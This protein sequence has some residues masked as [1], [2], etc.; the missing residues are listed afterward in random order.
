MRNLSEMFE[1]LSNCD[2]ETLM[3]ELNDHCDRLVQKNGTKSERFYKVD[4]ENLS[5][6]FRLTEWY[7]ESELPKMIEE[8]NPKSSADEIMTVEG[9]AVYMKVPPATVYNLINKGKLKKI[10]IS[11]VD[12]PGVRPAIRIRKSEIEIYL[13]GK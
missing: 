5:T 13:D 11:T 3:N 8:K 10:E 12:K 1:F 6:L 7:L 9:A 4:V 2:K